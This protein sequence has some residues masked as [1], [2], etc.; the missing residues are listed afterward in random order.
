MSRIY[1]MNE[2]SEFVIGELKAG[3]I[4][5]LTLHVNESEHSKEYWPFGVTDG[6]NYMFFESNML[7]AW[8]RNDER[9]IMNLLGRV[10][11]F[12]EYIG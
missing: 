8:G 10:G 4:P 2:M 3:R 12:C 1:Q 6:A 5:G 7:L 9:P 11:I